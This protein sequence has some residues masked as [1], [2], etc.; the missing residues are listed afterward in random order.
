MVCKLAKLIM[1][2]QIITEQILERPIMKYACQYSIIRFM[3]FVET[4][5]FANIGIALFCPETGYFNFQISDRKTRKVNS[6]FAPVPTHIYPEGIKDINAEL[7][8]IK[9]LIEGVRQS[10]LS[11]AKGIFYELVRTRE[12]TFR[13]SEIRGILTD[14]METKTEELF[15]H[16]V[17]RGLNVNF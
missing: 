17:E 15:S 2:E 13:F 10:D 9:K 12:G 8:R 7:A 16:Y 14:N 1:N 11:F 3:P 5:E 6:F 4:G